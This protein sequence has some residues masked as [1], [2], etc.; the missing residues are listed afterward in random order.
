MDKVRYNNNRIIRERTK[1]ESTTDETTKAQIN[2][3]IQNYGQTTQTDMVRL[4]DYMGKYNSWSQGASKA[5]ADSA[6]LTQSL[7][8]SIR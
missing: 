4:E 2:A 3:K 1:L 5:L 6:Q 7:A 8:S